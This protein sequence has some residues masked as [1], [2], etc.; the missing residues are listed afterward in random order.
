MAEERRI[1]NG[2][3]PAQPEANAA[4]SREVMDDRAISSSGSSNPPSF[5]PSLEERRKTG[6]TKDKSIE[7]EEAVVDVSPNVSEESVCTTEKTLEKP[8]LSPYVPLSPLHI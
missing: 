1:L 5:N 6:V 4:G 3:P 7:H 2:L 8:A